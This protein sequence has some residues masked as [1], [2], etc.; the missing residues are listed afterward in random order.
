ML[1]EQ[2]MVKGT[3]NK[4]I[5]VKYLDI[6][7]ES[8]ML[9]ERFSNLAF[10]TQKVFILIEINDNLLYIKYSYIEMTIKNSLVR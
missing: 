5:T 3:R 9:F 8:W 10:K 4:I 2:E 1:I 7:C 6:Y